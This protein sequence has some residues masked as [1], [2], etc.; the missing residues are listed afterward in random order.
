VAA[1]TC[2]ANPNI[3]EL[4]TFAAC[5][6]VPPLTTNNGLPVWSTAASAEIGMPPFRTTNPFQGRSLTDSWGVENVTSFNFTDHLI[7]R[8]IFGYRRD[9]FLSYQDTDGTIFP[10]QGVISVDQNRRTTDEAQLQGSFERL[11]WIVGAYYSDN[12][13]ENHGNYEVAEPDSPISPVLLHS[14]NG[15][16]AYA[17]YAQATYRITDRL[18]LTAGYRHTEEDKTLF[19]AETLAGFCGLSPG[20]GVDLVTCTENQKATFV[21]P[22]WTFGPD[23]KITDHMLAYVTTRRGFNAGGFSLPGR[24][25]FATEKLTDVEIGL[26]TDWSL[27]GRPLQANLAL[28]RSDYADIQRAIFVFVNNVPMGV[29]ANAASADVYGAELQLKANLSRYFEISAGG[30]WI[31]AKYN[32]FIT[33]I[34]P[35]QYVNLT[36]NTLADAPK[37]STTISPRFRVPI[38]PGIGSD[39]SLTVTWSYQSRIFFQDSNQTNAFISNTLDTY[40]QQAGYSLFNAELAWKQVMGSRSDVRFYGKNLGDKIYADVTSNNL[41]TYGVANAIYGEPRT[42]GVSFA[43]HFA[44]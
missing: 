43:Y 16:K 18:N 17:L 9:H 40:S 19:N 5:K 33:E 25:P 29:T 39:L 38:P 44:D 37:V 11:T 15:D 28:Y 22:S 10:L 27:A 2:S 21:E 4:L 41:S 30:S 8:N 13:I 24:P 3:G 12:R 1:G 23:F 35:G 32:N 26:K 6:Y 31:D 7:L 42:W 20:P 36:S 34:Q 14:I